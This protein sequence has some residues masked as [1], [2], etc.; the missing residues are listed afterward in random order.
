M[1]GVHAVDE[2]RVLTVP[3]A[4]RY[5]RLSVSTVY[6]LLH[7]GVLPGVKVGNSW[8]IPLDALSDYLHGGRPPGRPPE[9]TGGGR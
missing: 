3:E 9:S 2:G 6:R 7:R 1:V 5:L 4:A 8:R